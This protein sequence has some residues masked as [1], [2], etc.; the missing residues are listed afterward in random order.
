MVVE[1]QPFPPMQFL[2]NTNLLLQNSIFSRCSSFSHPAIANSNIRIGIVNMAT[3]LP[4]QFE[5]LRPNPC[6]PPCPY[7]LICHRLSRR[8]TG[9]TGRQK[10]ERQ[11]ALW[12]ATDEIAK[13]PGHPFYTRL[14]AMF[15]KAGFDRWVEK[16][17]QRFYAKEGRPGIPP[18]VYF[19]MLMIGY[20]E[21]L[22]SE[23]GIAWRCAD[24]LTLRA[25]AREPSSPKR[26]PRDPSFVGAAAS[27]SPSCPAE[28][29]SR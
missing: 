25:W 14:N 4:F 5:A 22:E 1:P 27:V 15:A 3:S 12:V 10:S 2:Q 21:G 7:L 17:C 13:G 11:D 24:S 9:G 18:G 26:Y 20:F 29:E 6:R 8:L 28:R 19:R 16:R 23:R